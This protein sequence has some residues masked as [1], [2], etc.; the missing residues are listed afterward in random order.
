MNFRH[1]LIVTYGRS[2]STLLQGLLNS[3]DG[4]LVRGE[5]FNACRGLF[6]AYDAIRETR[7]KNGEMSSSGCATSPWYGAFLLDEERFLQDAREMLLHQLVPEESAG[8]YHCI[9]F[10]EVRYLGEVWPCTVD[11]AEKLSGYLDFLSRLLPGCALVFLTRDHEQVVGSAWW[12]GRNPVL[13]KERLRFFEEVLAQYAEGKEWVYQLDYSDLVERSPRVRGLFDFLG[14]PYQEDRVEEVLSTR[15]SFGSAPGKIQSA[16]ERWVDAESPSMDVSTDIVS[17]S[18]S[19]PGAR[20]ISVR[21]RADLQVDSPE[22]LRLVLRDPCGSVAMDRPDGKAAEGMPG[23]DA[24]SK[25]RH[26]LTRVD[27]IRDGQASSI[28][29]IDEMGNDYCLATIGVGT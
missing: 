2:G 18:G 4:C 17:A 6:M 3:I 22:S 7:R 16:L 10:K 24:D 19:S 1:L 13:L 20:R 21:I 23:D 8:S 12:R 28:Y 14:T 9:G 15:H 11:A 5:N 26:L 29:V 27:R 25:V